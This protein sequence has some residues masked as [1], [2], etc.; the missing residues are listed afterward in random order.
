[1]STISSTGSAVESANLGYQVSIAVAAKTQQVMKD[2]G[3]AMLAL[4]EQAAQ[5]AAQTQAQSLDPRVGQN[6]NVMG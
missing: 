4:L 3:Q 6:L 5:V 1:M 2:Q